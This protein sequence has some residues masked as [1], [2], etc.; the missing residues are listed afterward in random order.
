MSLAAVAVGVGGVAT[1]G[2]AYMAASGAKS[3]AN[4]QLALN[5]SNQKMIEDSNLRGE[6]MANATVLGVD[7]AIQLAQAKYGIDATRILGQDAA[8]PNFNDQQRARVAEL[9]QLIANG[10]RVT[11]DSQGRSYLPWS[12]A[13]K[14]QNSAASVAERLKSAQA[15]RDAL[16]KAAGGK[17]GQTGLIDKKYL[18]GLGPSIVDRQN[19]MV[20]EQEQ[21]YAGLSAD[22]RGIQD[23]I[24]RYG[25]GEKD[26]IYRD[27]E[28]DLTGLNRTSKAALMAKGLGAGS[29]MTGALTK[30]TLAVGESR[31]DQLSALGDRQI[32]MQSAAASDK[33]NLDRSLADSIYGFKVQ[34]INTELSLATGAQNSPYLGFDPRSQTAA[35]PGG[36]FSQSFGNNLSALGGQAGNL[37]MLALLTKNNP[38]L[39]G[40]LQ[41][42]G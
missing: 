23:M 27:S 8:D 39:A 11:A 38:A 14:T 25:E 37:G 2:G 3:Q 20:K 22:A 9:D 12:N 32:Q 1:L 35:S 29:A 42:T 26:R 21:K 15:E 19:T 18:Q 17:V 41:N 34:P 33:L 24:A 7:R 16:V 5:E 6:I 4:A 13:N 40:A 10:G 30:N 31:G 36:A 28:R